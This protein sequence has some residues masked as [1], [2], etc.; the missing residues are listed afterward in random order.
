MYILFAAVACGLAWLLDVTFSCCGL[1][2]RTRQHAADHAPPNWRG[3][4]MSRFVVVACVVAPGSTLPTMRRRIGVVAGCYFRLVPARRV[5]AF[6]RR[7]GCF[8]RV[9]LATRR[10]PP[11]RPKKKIGDS[12]WRSCITPQHPNNYG[13]RKH[14][15]RSCPW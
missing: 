11:R 12:C 3:C 14:V 8:R 15:A 9:R 1:R 4:W 10:L 13:K 2:R 6:V 7:P 5:Q